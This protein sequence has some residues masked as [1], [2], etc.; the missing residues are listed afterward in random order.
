MAVKS[1]ETYKNALRHH[2]EVEKALH[3]HGILPQEGVEA[4][5]RILA[6]GPTSQVIVSTSNILTRLQRAEAF[7]LPER[8]LTLQSSGQEPR[9]VPTDTVLHQRPD[10]Q[11]AYIA[12]QNETQQQVVDIW[13]KLLD[14]EQI[15]IHDNFM[16]LGGDSLLGT[17]L[18]IRLRDTFQVDL[19]L[20]SLFEEPTVAGLAL[21]I[22]QR[23]AEH[24]D[25][26]LLLQD[27]EDMEHLT[28]EEVQALL[29]ADT[30]QSELKK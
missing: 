12:P 26:A 2:P 18:I 28:N 4:F 16:D 17:Q 22:V 5:R 7:F 19:S 24:I 20:L 15:G 30:N 9:S 29:A 13:Q 23:K 27:I 1:L 11:T 3:Q 6:Y 21:A 10:L 8:L 25:D 14:I